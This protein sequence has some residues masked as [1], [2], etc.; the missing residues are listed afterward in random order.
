MPPSWTSMTSCWPMGTTDPSRERGVIGDGLPRTV[1]EV[2]AEQ[3]MRRALEVAEQTPA[4]DIPVGAVVFGPDG[5]ELGAGTNRRE[6]DADP[7]GHAEIAAIRAAVQTLGDAWRL[8]E[9]TLVVTLEP[10]AMC[11]GAAV[12]ARIGTIIYGASEP[13]TGACGSVWDVP[14]EAPLHKAEVVGGVLAAECE[15]LLRDFFGELRAH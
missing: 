6:V 4:G 5:R 9:C 1:S 14:R 13:R 7:T 3:L 2:R 11:A 10:C 12:G 15:A 8:A